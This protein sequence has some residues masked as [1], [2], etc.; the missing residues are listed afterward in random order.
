MDHW[1]PYEIQVFEAA[2]DCFGKQF[3]RITQFLEKKTCCQVISFYYVW[4]KED[5][6]QALKV[7]SERTKDLSTIIKQ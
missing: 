4:K 6:Y 3:H 7:R 2:M 5:Y 1:S